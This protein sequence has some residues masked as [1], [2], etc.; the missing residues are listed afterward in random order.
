MNLP[1]ASSPHWVPTITAPGIGDPP[2]RQAAARVKRVSSHVGESVV[3]RLRRRPFEN[4]DPAPWYCVR[5]RYATD[6]V[7]GAEGR[8]R[9]VYPTSSAVSA[10]SKTRPPSG[11]ASTTIVASVAVRAFEQAHCDRVRELPLQHP[12]ERACA[13]VG[14][15]ARVR[16]PC[17]CRVGEIESDAALGEPRA[18]LRELDVDDARD[19]LLRQ[20]VEHDD[21]VDPVHEL[22]LEVRAHRCHHRVLVAARAEVARHDDDRVREVDR[23]ALAV[24]EPAVV[25]QLQQHVEHVGVRLLDL[26]EQHDRV[27]AGAAPPRVSW[28]PSS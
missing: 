5:F 4:L 14:V 7:P 20:T 13:V 8:A 10:A 19:V 22:G 18:Q 11:V 23:A 17:A 12:L 15:V 28:P 9:T 27:R 21:L 24:G 26:V 25:H 16:D 6:A 3:D 1:F 2:G